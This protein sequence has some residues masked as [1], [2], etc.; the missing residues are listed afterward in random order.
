MHRVAIVGAGHMGSN[1]ARVAAESGDAEIAVVVDPD[2][3]RA[4]QLADK[5]HCGWAATLDHVDGIDLAIV[6]SATATHEACAV[7]LLES[8]VPTLVE[9][10][11]AQELASVERIIEA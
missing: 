2:E 11:L 10:P 8:G 4:R 7:P 9:K 3:T 5:H 1:H 6:A